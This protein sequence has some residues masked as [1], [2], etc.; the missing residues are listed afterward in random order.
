MDA[1]EHELP[2]RDPRSVLHEADYWA[3]ILGELKAACEIP[4]RIAGP[5]AEIPVAM[6]ELVLGQGTPET[7][8]KI[9]ALVK[10]ALAEVSAIGDRID[11]V[12]E[13]AGGRLISLRREAGL[14]A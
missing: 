13:L 14:E 1:S 11:A 12:S 9:G 6:I 3:E 10:Q 2:L 7:V 8:E 5:L 4:P